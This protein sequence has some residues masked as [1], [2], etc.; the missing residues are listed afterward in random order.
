MVKVSEL[1]RLF[2]RYYPEAHCALDYETPEQ[3]TVA[4]VLSAQ[5][6]DERVNIV[7]RSL[8]KRYPDLESLSR[9]SLKEIE[10]EV[11]STGFYKNKAKNL[12]AL[13]QIVVK[14]YSGKVPQNLEELVS[15]PGVGRKTANVVLGNA[16]GVASGVV[17]DTHVSRLSRR[18]GLTQQKTPEKIEEELNRIIP[19]KYWIMFSHWLIWHGRGPC[20]ARRPSCETCF[21]DSICPKNL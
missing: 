4:T 2:K 5:C 19:K 14:K 7:T 18:L 16:F 10:K 6:T 17:V 11:H 15:L 8:F 12:K 9:A 1:V 20:K 21:L 13:S 3:L